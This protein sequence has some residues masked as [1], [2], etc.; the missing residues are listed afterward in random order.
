MRKVLVVLNS[1]AGALLRRDATE[2]KREVE[3][4][5][6]QRGRTIVVVLA[7]GAS[8]ARAIDCAAAGD[9]DAIVVG[10]G[11][12]SASYAARRLAGTDKVLG[13]LP[14]GTLNLLAGDIGM[15]ASLDDALAAL[16]T[17]MPR[18]V[19][20]GLLN[21][22][23]FHTLS[24][25][26][27][28]SQMARAREETRDIPGKL[29]RTATA[30]IRALSRTGRFTLDIVVDGR[31]RQIDSYAVLVTVNC[32]AADAWRRERLDAGTLEVHIAEDLGVLARLK[33]GAGLLAGDWRNNPGIHSFRAQ[34]VS[35]DTWRQRTWVSTDGELMRERIP[36][37]YAIEPRA[38]RLLVP[39]AGQGAR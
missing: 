35:I 23:P 8:I 33:T 14:L 32:F 18:P 11:D 28:F 25:V 36:L 16:N 6:A 19:D 30:A 20:L 12:G 27:F 15:P 17:A 3:R 21:G 9:H 37:R 13:L 1:R 31:P 7:R 29:L 24:G 5:L 38:L 26:G 39:T 22:R 4:A 10:G 2:V 34:R